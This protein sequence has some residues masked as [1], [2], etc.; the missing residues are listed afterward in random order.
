MAALAACLF[1]VNRALRSAD[2]FYG[3][4][5]SAAVALIIG[6]ETPQRYLGT[7]WLALAAVL[8]SLGWLRRLKDFRI[9]SY[10][11]ALL[12]LG[13]TAIYQA[14][15]AA[16]S[17]PLPRIRGSRSR[18]R[19]CSATAACSARCDR[20]TIDSKSGSAPA[21]RRF[22][23]WTATL[24]LVALA[25][26]VLPGDYLGLGWIVAALLLLELGLRGVP[27]DFRVQAYAVAALGGARVLLFNLI[28]VTNTGAWAPRLTIAGAALLAYA[29]AVRIYRA[30]SA[31]PS[32]CGSSIT[33]LR[34][35]RYSRYPRLGRCCLRWRL[36]RRGPS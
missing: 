7:A 6:F 25:W 11:G 29:F 26:R 15:V 4:A 14:N 2:K 12:G 1:Y 18:F 21:L 10:L 17:A 27:D 16:G 28:P 24:A 31:N 32:A 19:R 8:F 5:G 30:S 33:A 3:Y 35:G 36:V 20:R 34:A 23:S 22:G 9:Q 13:G